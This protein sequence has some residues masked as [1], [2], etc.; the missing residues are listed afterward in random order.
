MPVHSAPRVDQNQPTILSRVAGSWRN[1]AKIV[2][3]TSIRPASMAPP[4][5]GSI[6]PSRQP[7][8]TIVIAHLDKAFC[9]SVSAHL[10]E[11]GLTVLHVTSAKE[12]LAKVH[13]PAVR[14]ILLDRGLKGTSRLPLCRKIRSNPIT[15]ELPIILLSSENDEVDRIA[16][17]E[18]CADDYVTTP[19]NSRELAL[20]VQAVLRRTK[21]WRGTRIAVGSIIVDRQ[22]QVV[23]AA[24]RVL[25]LTETEL[26][27]LVHL[28]DR[29]SVP[30]S[31]DSLL[32]AVWGNKSAADRR[33]V[34]TCIR[35]LRTKL[36]TAREHVKTVAGFGYCLAA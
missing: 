15:S 4:D 30:Q 26:R 9:A 7:A 1:R 19:C 25:S 21:D 34:D 5:K 2:L 13:D 27:L 24:G 28:A 12:L 29:P 18:C 35:R 8:D 22:K 14:L 23:S 32:A 11:D 6:A 36:G 31:R 16:G 3:Q 33:S 17:F 20:R 10:R